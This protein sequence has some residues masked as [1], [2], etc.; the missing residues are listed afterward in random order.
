[1]REL[2]TS[3]QRLMQEDLKSRSKSANTSCL[4][5]RVNL[6]QIVVSPFITIYRRLRVSEMVNSAVVVCRARAFNPDAAA[7]RLPDVLLYIHGRRVTGK[8]RR[9]I[10]ERI[11]VLA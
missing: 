3:I 7:M 1:M 9:V 5:N 6:A 2:D 11:D 4:E 8:A 10:V